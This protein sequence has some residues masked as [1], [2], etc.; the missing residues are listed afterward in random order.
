MPWAV[1]LPQKQWI[2]TLA[3]GKYQGFNNSHLAEKPCREENLALS[4]ETVR[5]AL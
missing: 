4:R 2:L 1:S 3:R 5:R